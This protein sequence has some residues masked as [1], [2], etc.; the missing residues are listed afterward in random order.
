MA[1]HETVL[2]DTPESLQRALALLDGL[3]VV[4]IDVER[5]DWD[6]YWR[7]AA[8]IQVGGEGRVALVD[9]LAL[10]D[11]SELGDLLDERTSVLHAMDNDLGPLDAVGVAPE[12]PEDT[13]IAAAVLGLPLG[14]ET[15]LKDLLDVELEGDKAAMQRSDWE[16]RPLTDEMLA[17][18][19][20]DVADLPALWTVLQA[21]LDE[22]GRTEWY[23]QEL[24]AVRSL[25]PAEQRRDWAR[26]KGIGR[27]DPA[28]RARVQAL[29]STR[30]DLARATDTA[31]S[32]IAS[33]KLLVDLAL[34]PPTSTSEL[35]RRGMRRAAVRQFGA[36]LLGA[37]GAA[38][39]MVATP[40][41]RALRPPTE[42][43]RAMVD[44][45]RALRSERAEELGIDAGVL[46]PS[47]TLMGAVLADPMDTDALRDALGLRPWQFEQL[48]GIFAQAFGIDGAGTQPP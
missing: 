36:Q 14:L 35:G 45:L 21:R 18:A 27:L 44:R 3:D 28:A 43:D 2:A 38:Q 30:E 48:G 26:T 13:A 37:I 7:A 23:R 5:A 39:A 4:G 12:L 46:C 20:G 11:L 40:G 29:W 16:A 32:R 47:R 24:E 1:V 22:A 34:H 42:A 9:P 15:L 8:L 31:P 41:R 19:A 17:Y 10:P 33:D 25:P 6:R